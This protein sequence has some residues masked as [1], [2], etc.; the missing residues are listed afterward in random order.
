MRARG[1]SRS[2]C[3]RV[4]ACFPE[5]KKRKK[6]RRTASTSLQVGVEAPDMAAG[7]IPIPNYPIGTKGGLSGHLGS[8]LKPDIVADRRHKSQTRL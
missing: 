2:S 5:L 7:G 8:V 6:G 4:L 3:C 1:G